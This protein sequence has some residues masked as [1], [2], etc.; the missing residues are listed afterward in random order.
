MA[1]IENTTFSKMV[2]RML[3]LG[4]DAWNNIMLLFLGVG[5]IAAVGV[6]ISTYCVVQLQRREA[7]DDAERI[8]TLRESNLKLEARLA[9]RLKY[10]GLR[11]NVRASEPTHHFLKVRCY[12]V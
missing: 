12:R 1:Q 9:P 2:R 11:A 10:H 8:E 7:V 6:G 3:G 5:G 4:L